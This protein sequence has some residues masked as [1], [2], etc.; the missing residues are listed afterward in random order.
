M[1][2]AIHFLKPISKIFQIIQRKD[3]ELLYSNTT[4]TKNSNITLKKKN[5]ETLP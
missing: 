3:R 5:W 4:E 1:P 2:L